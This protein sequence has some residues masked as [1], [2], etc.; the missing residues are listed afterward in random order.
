VERKNA[1]ESYVYDTCMALS[2]Y[3]EPYITKADRDI[4]SRE[5]SNTKD[6]LYGREIIQKERPTLQNLQS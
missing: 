1:V 6:W 4:F 2:D 5:L 3:L